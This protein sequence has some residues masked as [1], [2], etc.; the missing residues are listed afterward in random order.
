MGHHDLFEVDGVH[1]SRLEDM[2]LITGAGTFASDWILPGQLHAFFLRA[3][4][5]H[6]KILSI[7]TAAARQHPGVAGI[8]TGEDA[9]RSGYV[10]SATFLNFKGKNDMEGRIPERPV[11]AHG[12]VR[13]VGEPVAL[14]VA[15][16]ALAAQDAA[17]SIRIEYEDL[18]VIIDPEQA[19]APGAPRAGERRAGRGAPARHTSSGHA[20]HLS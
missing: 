8:Y 5:A 17:E 15:D 20:A 2:R 12:R 4:R 3:D 14:V 11:L 19:L 7:D 6:A 13:F 16:S 9:V 18:P 1:V 10:R